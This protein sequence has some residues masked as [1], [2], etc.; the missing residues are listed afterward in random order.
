ML[1]DLDIEIINEAAIF[2]DNPK[3]KLKLRFFTEK[4]SLDILKGKQNFRTK[5]DEKTVCKSNVM[6]N[7]IDKS[8][9]LVKD[10]RL[11]SAESFEYLVPH[12]SDLKINN[13]MNEGQRKFHVP[14]HQCPPLTLGSLMNFKITKKPTFISNGDLAFQQGSAKLWRP[15]LAQV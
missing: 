2:G 13:E 1:K 9:K 3:P 11:K 6:E 4:D 7:I 5:I 14:V 10:D 15:K 8:R 12:K